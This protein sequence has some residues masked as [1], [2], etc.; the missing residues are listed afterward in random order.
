MRY[1]LMTLWSLLVVLAAPLHAQDSATLEI[2]RRYTQRFYDGRD[3]ELWTLFLPQLRKVLGGQEA[4]LREFRASTMNALGDEA[5]VVRERTARQA[6]LRVYTRT[7][8]FERTGTAFDVV[9]GIDPAGRIGT[10]LVRPSESAAATAA[11]SKYE[12][13]RTK[14]PL[15]LPFTGDWTVFWGGRTIEQN[16]HAASGD[17]RFAYDLVVTRNGVTHDGDQ[18]RNERYF[19]FGQ[20]VVAPG[21]GTVVH[22]VDGIPDNVPGEMNPAQPPGNHVVIDHGNGEFSFLAHL[23]QGSVAVRPGERVAGGAPLGAC[24]NSGNSSEPHL[25]YHLQTTPT[26]GDGEG[27]PA[28][29]LSYVADGSNVVRGELVRGQRVRPGRSAP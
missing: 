22:A 17:Q 19:C 1:P 14:T 28:Q 13:Y 25:H 4:K 2:G 7:A 16:Y 5:A 8:R 11:P 23:R 3:A 29:F 20:P 21:A 24:G 26:F 9:W 12:D 15:R 10:F 27:L 6:G 18:R